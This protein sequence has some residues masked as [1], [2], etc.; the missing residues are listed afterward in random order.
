MRSCFRPPVLP[1][2][3]SMPRERSPGSGRA[4]HV[5]G[6][7]ARALPRM[8]SSVS[9]S[10]DGGVIMSARDLG[11]WRGRWIVAVVPRE[12]LSAHCVR[13]A[14]LPVR[15]APYNYASSS[16]DAGQPPPPQRFGS[17][18]SSR[19][20]ALPAQ[21]LS[22]LAVM[23]RR[24]G[25]GLTSGHGLC[26]PWKRQNWINLRIAAGR[27]RRCAITGTG[28]SPAAGRK[29]A[30]SARL[31]RNWRSSARRPAGS[32]E[33]GSM[34][35]LLPVESYEAN[36]GEMVRYRSPKV[37]ASGTCWPGWTRDEKLFWLQ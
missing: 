35:S 37:A 19:W 16:T 17:G 32:R 3:V 31:H 26:R 13:R 2:P 30:R 23:N 27:D 24:A 11:P 15:Q 28:R 25:T 7:Q 36:G 8:D 34:T 6:G 9:A 5:G 21:S 10:S 18:F 22:V 4:L 20:T 33:C 1:L 29:S 14:E 12:A